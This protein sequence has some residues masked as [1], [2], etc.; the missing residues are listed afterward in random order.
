VSPSRKRAA[1]C[2]LR[3]KFVVSERRACEVLNQPRSCQRYQAKPRDDEPR[4]IAR[5]RELARQR[6]RFG[7]RRI[8]ALLRR[9][10]WSASN[11]RVL[12]LWRQEGLK[13]PQKKRKRRRLGTSANSCDR[14]RAEHQDHVWCWDF[15]FDR[16]ASGSALKWLSIVDE[17]TRECL[18]LKVDRSITSEDVIDTLAELFAMRGVPRCIRSD[19]G[20][21]FIA[22][23]I[24]RW[25]G[26]VDVQ[27]LYVEPGSPWENGYAESFHSRVRDE[28]LALEIFDNLRAARELTA[29][30]RED[31][32][33]H[34]PHGSLGYQTPAEF[35]ACAASAPA[36]PALQQ[37]T[38]RDEDNEERVPFSQTVPS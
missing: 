26:Q 21:E 37:H 1:V 31:Y 35:A 18:A 33:H 11:T 10:A 30:W 9:E 28:F 15:V 25:L 3:E 14:Q 27:T 8:G 17:Y 19:N 13:V 36:A 6:P 12:R 4:L 24:R 32:N 29:A 23:A 5:M 34:R 20:P 2:G 16:T 7:Y 22:H 38:Q